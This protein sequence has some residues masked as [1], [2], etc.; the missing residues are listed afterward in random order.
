[1]SVTTAS[2][3]EL[4]QDHVEDSG[5]PGATDSPLAAVK[6]RLA[7]KRV[8]VEKKVVESAVGRLINLFERSG[9]VQA[10]HAEVGWLVAK[11]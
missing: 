6:A 1:M 9:V 2:P 7:L 3:D 4:A 8:V 10:E 5:S 11:W